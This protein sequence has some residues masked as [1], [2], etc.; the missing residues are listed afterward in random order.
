[1]VPLVPSTIEKEHHNQGWTLSTAAP[2]RGLTSL[3]NGY[4]SEEISSYPCELDDYTQKEIVRFIEW[5]LFEMSCS[6][7]LTNMCRMSWPGRLLFSD[8][9][10]T[11]FKIWRKC[12][13]TILFWLHL[14]N[15]LNTMYHTLKWNIPYQNHPKQRCSSCNSHLMSSCIGRHPKKGRKTR[16]APRDS[17]PREGVGLVRCQKAEWRCQ[18]KHQS[19]GVQFLC[20]T[21]ILMARTQMLL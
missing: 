4:D 18:K 3:Y 16:R 9:P 11:I 10:Q 19:H 6:C 2:W 20:C 17:V 14:W 7:I 13:W 12:L 8:W 21:Q 15:P 5:Q 1:M